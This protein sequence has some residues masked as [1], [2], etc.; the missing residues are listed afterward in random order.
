MNIF[1]LDR[2]P[3]AAAR[4]H[5]DKHV[6]KMILETAQLLSTAWH[7]LAP[8]CVSSDWVAT[9]PYFRSWADD[10]ETEFKSRSV[11]CYYLG[12]HRIYAR[13]HEN[14]PSAMWVRETAEAYD[15]AWRFGQELLAEYSYRYDR[16]HASAPILAAL[17]G[18]PPGIP[19]GPLSEPNVAMPDHCIVTDAEGYVDALASYRNYYRTE[20]VRMLTYTKRRPP[21]W[22]AD[23]ATYKEKR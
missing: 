17:E 11:V 21:D 14:H 3:L 19:D 9:D 22:V 6:V 20:K 4:A 5:C 18:S 12:N 8:Q 15:W 23:L 10:R 2:T 16:V 7:V 1:Y 13:T